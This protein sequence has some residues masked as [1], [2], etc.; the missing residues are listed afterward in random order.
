MRMWERT[1]PLEIIRPSLLVEKLLSLK[2][3]AQGN[4][5]INKSGRRMRTCRPYHHANPYS[6]TFE[7]GKKR[8]A[9]NQESIKEG[10]K[11][12]EKFLTIPEL[13]SFR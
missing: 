2:V 5:V 9:K 3:P 13:V 8:A 12:S 1:G 4:R 7:L 10:I 11:M 6:P